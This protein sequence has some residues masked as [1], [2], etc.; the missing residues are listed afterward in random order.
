MK[1]GIIIILLAGISEILLFL[2]FIGY[3]DRDIYSS[4]DGDDLNSTSIVTSKFNSNY[5]VSFS[6]F[7]DKNDGSV[8]LNGSIYEIA[9]NYLNDEDYILIEDTTKSF[10]NIE[11]IAQDI[12]FQFRYT[13]LD[14]DEEIYIKLDGKI[15]Y[16]LED[17]INRHGLY[18]IITEKYNI[19]QTGNGV[20]SYGKIYVYDKEW[21]ELL[22]TD[23]TAIHGQQSGI[24]YYMTM[25]NGRLYFVKHVD[26]IDTLSYIDFNEPDLHIY[27]IESKNAT[28][29]ECG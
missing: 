11:F 4:E 13:N 21:D 17:S 28:G 19:I 26:C 1:K 8:I 23:S 6:N 3:I 9:K 16:I 25:Y 20:T 18:L 24:L 22:S 12:K 27:E 5:V 2:G 29:N 14:L 10:D 15:E 7:P